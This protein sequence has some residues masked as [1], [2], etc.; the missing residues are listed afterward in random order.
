VVHTEIGFKGPV[1]WRDAIRVEDRCTRIGFT[2][3]TLG[4]T[5]LRSRDAERP[6]PPVLR[7]ALTSVGRQAHNASD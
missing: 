2:G 6:I 5:V 7:G 1:R 3:F 4:F